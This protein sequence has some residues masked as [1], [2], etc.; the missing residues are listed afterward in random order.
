VILLAAI[1]TLTLIKAVH[2]ETTL[3]DRMLIPLLGLMLAVMGN[4]MIN[5]KP[6][7]FV[8]IRIPWALNS[9]Y[10]WRKTHQ[11]GG[12]VWFVGGLLILIMGVFFPLEAIEIL[13][14][15]TIILMVLIPSVYSFMIFKKESS[16][17]DYYE[18]LND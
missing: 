1:N 12:K 17:P 10:N 7:Y 2:P 4:Y 18:K 3:M 11:L 15:S 5:I 9:E 8:G 13:F 6:N 16:N 14:V